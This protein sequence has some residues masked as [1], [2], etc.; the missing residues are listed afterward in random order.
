MCQRDSWETDL[1]LPLRR[2]SKRWKVK[3]ILHASKSRWEVSWGQYGN[4]CNRISRIF[5]ESRV[6]WGMK[7]TLTLVIPY[8]AHE[9]RRRRWCP[10]LYPNCDKLR[11][12]RRA[13]WGF[14]S[15]NRRI[16][17]VHLHASE[18]LR[19]DLS[20]FR[21]SWIDGRGS[22]KAKAIIHACKIGGEASRGNTATDVMHFPHFLRISCGGWKVHEHLS[23]LSRW[24][25][26]PVL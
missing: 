20:L 14:F 2:S 13:A 8:V 25:C 10:V 11:E 12:S 24:L 18:R 26:S 6:G 7:G 23:D 19:R 15:V 3:V 4:G 9:L 21:R 5:Q 1:T 16:S 17:K 22:W